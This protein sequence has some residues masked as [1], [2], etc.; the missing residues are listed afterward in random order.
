MDTEEATEAVP[1]AT[2]PEMLEDIV[3]TPVPQKGKHRKEQTARQRARPRG[4]DSLPKAM[5][6]RKKGMN[7]WVWGGSA[8]AAMLVILLVVVGYS[9]LS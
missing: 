9:Y 3:E 2:E 8:A 7:Y 6:K 4:T 5:L 1:E